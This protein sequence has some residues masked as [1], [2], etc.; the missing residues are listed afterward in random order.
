MEIDLNDPQALT[1]EN[2][3]KLIASKDDSANRQIRVTK[4]GRVSLSDVVGSQ[5]LENLAFR[6]E[7]MGRGN[8]YVG[9]DAAADDALVQ[10]IY[11]ALKKNWPT[12]TSTYVEAL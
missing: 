12:P 2:V 6:F 9:P 3:R 11:D 7:T 10:R 4:D 1:L 8:G 5:D